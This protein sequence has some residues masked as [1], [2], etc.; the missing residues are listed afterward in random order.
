MLV[1]LPPSWDGDLDGDLDGAKIPSSWDQLRTMYLGLGMVQLQRWRMC[2]GTKDNSHTPEVLAPSD[3][4]NY[5]G[6]VLYCLCDTSTRKNKKLKRDCI[7]C[8][9]KCKVCH[10]QRKEMVAFDYVPIG[11]QIKLMTK[12]RTFCHE[13]LSM[14]FN[15]DKWLNTE[16]NYAP[17]YIYDFWDGQKCRDYREFWDPNS[18]YE[19]PVICDQ[20]YCKKIYRAFPRSHVSEV[21]RGSWKE[22]EQLYKFTC[23]KCRKPIE[24]KRNLVKVSDLFSCSLFSC[25]SICHDLGCFLIL[26][27]SAGR[28]TKLW[29]FYPF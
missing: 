18:T 11:Q 14:W 7:S 10:I 15:K 23:E 13:F 1:Q 5:S 16:V 26:T 21:L 17:E 19:L 2:T 6:N 20:P 27:M 24:A 12:S 3:E 8:C 25:I 9:E 4:D 22:E 28:S 29:S